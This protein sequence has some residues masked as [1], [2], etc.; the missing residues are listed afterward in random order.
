MHLISLVLIYV[1][2]LVLPWS[3]IVG[4][5]A[6]GV[7]QLVGMIVGATG[8]G[9][10]GTGESLDA[11]RERHETKTPYLSAV[12]LLQQCFNVAMDQ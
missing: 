6:I 5:V 12:S 10:E 3:G 8:E 9:G 2:A 7:P 11:I 1:P 4:P